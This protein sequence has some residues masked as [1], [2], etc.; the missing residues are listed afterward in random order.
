[1]LTTH[2]LVNLHYIIRKNFNRFSK[3]SIGIKK[4]FISK[5]FLLARDAR[6]LALELVQGLEIGIAKN[7]RK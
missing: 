3:F 6:L 1:M 5:P 2:Y 7:V 4:T